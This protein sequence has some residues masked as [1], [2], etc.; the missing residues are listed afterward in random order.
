VRLEEVLAHLRRLRSGCDMLLIEGA[1]GLLSPLGENFNARDLISALRAAPLIVCPNRLGAINQALL[2]RAALPPSAA[3]RSE[4]VLMSPRKPDA[5][6]RANAALLAGLLGEPRVHSLPWLAANVRDG[7][8][9]VPRSV[10]R[11]LDAVM[12]A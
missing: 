5:A 7:H 12:A 6:S 11:T 2:V 3:Q 8:G 10:R 4:V 1:G 9:S